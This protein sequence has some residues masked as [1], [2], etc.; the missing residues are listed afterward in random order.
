M[1]HVELGSLS[2]L[3]G[4]VHWAVAGMCLIAGIVLAGTAIVLF[5]SRNMAIAWSYPGRSG[6]ARKAEATDR[7]INRQR[8]ISPVTCAAFGA[9]CLGVVGNILMEL[10]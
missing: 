9:V 7:Q 5:A 4:A 2:M 1:P 3:P 8:W 10:L 6:R